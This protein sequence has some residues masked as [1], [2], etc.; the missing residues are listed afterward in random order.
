MHRAVDAGPA[1]VCVGIA[2]DR[3]SEVLTQT[4]IREGI[5]EGRIGEGS[6]QAS[7]NTS[8]NSIRPSSSVLMVPKEG[9]SMP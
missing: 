3:P 8:T 2:E 9:L 7:S 5:G 6:G 4:M 1:L